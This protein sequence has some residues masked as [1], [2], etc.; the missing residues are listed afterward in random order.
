MKNCIKYGI[1][2][3][4]AGPIFFNV[5]H[6]HYPIEPYI[7]HKNTF[8]LGVISQEKKLEM[9]RKARLGSFLFKRN[10]SFSM[11]AVE[12]LSCGTPIMIPKEDLQERGVRNSM[13]ETGIYD[14][15]T[16]QELSDIRYDGNFVECFEEAK[17]RD[18]IDC[19]RI[20]LKYSHTKMLE[21][22]EIAL[23]TI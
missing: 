21:S 10:P 16:L 11:A 5:H 2:G 6:E 4:F 13:E 23:Y 3:Y 9:Y 17:K 12:C 8:Y 20:S 19:Y 7:D 22:F 18:P 1:K 15:Q 14:K